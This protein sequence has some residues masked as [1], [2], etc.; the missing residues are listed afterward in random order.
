MVVRVDAM[1][2]IATS[3]VPSVALVT[4]SAPSSRFR[5]MFS[6]TT[7]ALSTSMPIPSASPPN[8]MMFSV[9]PKK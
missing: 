7:I 6:R 2:A 1:I 4:A 9:Y 5:K 8:V 3:R